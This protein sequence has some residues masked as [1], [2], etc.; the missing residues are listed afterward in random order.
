MEMT[1][2]TARAR[3]AL[4]P[5]LSETKLMREAVEYRGTVVSSI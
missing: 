5:T 3:N 4:A 2:H 1:E